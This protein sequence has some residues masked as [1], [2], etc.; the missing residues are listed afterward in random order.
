MATYYAA[1]ASKGLGDGSSEA[2]AIALHQLIRNTT[3]NADTVYATN[4]DGD[5][6]MNSLDISPQG[7]SQWT[8]SGRGTPGEGFCKLIGYGSVV[9]DGG[10]ITFRKTASPDVGPS[11][12]GLEFNGDYW[13]VQN[14]V[15]I[16]EQGDNAEAGF[17]LVGAQY[18]VFVNCGAYGW[19]TGFDSVP[20]TLSYNTYI[21]CRAEKCIDIGFNLQP[22]DTCIN[23]VALENGTASI[24]P[25]G[26]GDGF[27]ITG[28]DAHIS[29]I[30]CVSAYNGRA[31]FAEQSNNSGPLHS[32]LINCTAHGNATDGFDMV[33]GDASL[34]NGIMLHCV[35]T[36][37]GGYGVNGSREPSGRPLMAIRC[38]FNPLNETNTLGGV[39]PRVTGSPLNVSPAGTPY[40]FVD[41]ITADPQY[42]DGGSSPYT[43]GDLSVSAAGG[44]ADQ[45]VPVGG[46]PAMAAALRA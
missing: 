21:G 3:F 37:N 8:I 39:A 5:Y 35:A 11:A 4:A 46:F 15:T 19:G 31:G 43:E 27:R 34:N 29:L 33:P 22:G 20:S 13:F 24:S 30:G 17:D 10:V 6:S 44:F 18:S 25:E 14:V 23:S 38:A 12:T 26:T 40:D 42:I 7:G 36:N 16:F 2:N 28:N 41:D 1:P 45:A 32:R 9:G